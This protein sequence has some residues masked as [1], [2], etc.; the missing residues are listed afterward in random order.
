MSALVWWLRPAAAPGVVRARLEARRWRQR[1]R[2]LGTQAELA[3]GK[4]D[5]LLVDE[6]TCPRCLQ[7]VPVA[8]CR[9]VEGQLF[10]AP[11]RGRGSGDALA[12]RRP[13]ETR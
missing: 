9:W 4:L 3:G 5:G 8:E 13:E 12:R 2:R 11:H 7:L 10:H 6:L 1:N